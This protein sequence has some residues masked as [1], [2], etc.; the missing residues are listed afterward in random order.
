MVI[1]QVLNNNVVIV[2]DADGMER[3]IC[4]KGIAF[5]KKPGDEV[6]AVSYTHLYRWISRQ[7]NQES[8]CIP[9]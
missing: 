9:F 2:K 4:G 7:E 6:N 3:V 1:A 5:K 8:R